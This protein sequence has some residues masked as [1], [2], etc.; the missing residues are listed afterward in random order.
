MAT[1]QER[2]NTVLNDL[3]MATSDIQ[4]VG[5]ISPD[6]MMIADQLG[7]NQGDATAAMG[8]ALGSLAKRVTTTLKV[9]DFQE[10]NIRGTNAGILLFDIEGR[11]ALILTVAKAANLGLVLLEARQAQ[12]Q[13][14]QII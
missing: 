3:K 4:G 9:G 10:V 2:I 11:A 1:K 6:G 7:G 5:V 13:L 8:A 14:A 12:A